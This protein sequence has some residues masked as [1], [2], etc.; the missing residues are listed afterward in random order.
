MANF[1]PKI[2]DTGIG[3]N[4]PVSPV[5]D[6][7]MGDLFANVGKVGAA[8]F[9]VADQATQDNIKTQIQDQT[10][11]IQKEYGVQAASTLYGTD[12]SSPSQP[13]PKTLE[14]ASQTLKDNQTAFNQGRMN[15]TTYITRLD[16]MTRQ[17]KSQYPAYSDQIDTIVSG[18][19]GI[20]PANALQKALMEDM[21]SSA[22]ANATAH[23]KS[24]AYVLS[25]SQYAPPGA[26]ESINSGKS[27]VPEVMDFIQRSKSRE[28]SISQEKASIAA[29]DAANA[30]DLNKVQ[31]SARKIA[32]ISVNE[33]IAKGIGA[34]GT[35]YNKFQSTLNAAGADGAYTAEENA[36]IR[37][38]FNQL[39]LAAQSKLNSTFNDPYNDS[40]DSYATKLSY[41]DIQD[42]TSSAM[43]PISA[44][45]EAVVNKDYGVLSAAALSIG[46]ASN[47]AQTQVLNSEGGG[48]IMRMSALSKL[49]G[50]VVLNSVMMEGNFKAFTDVQRATSSALLAK[51]VVDSKP[52]SDVLNDYKGTGTVDPKVVNATISAT[53]DMITKDGVNPE[54]SYN[55]AVSLFSKNT[56]EVFK[57]IK[58]PERMDLYARLTSPA[59]SAKMKR[60]GETHPQLLQQY[61]QFTGTQF[62][63]LFKGQADTVSSS[64]SE[65]PDISVKYN[66]K[67]AQF[68]LVDNS[69]GPFQKGY[70]KQTLQNFMDFVTLGVHQSTKLEMVQ[71]VNKINKGLASL[72]AA[73]SI[74]GE[75]PSAVLYRT[76]G[77]MVN[78]NKDL[79]F[80]GDLLT[81]IRD[82]V[83]EDVKNGASGASKSPDAT[84][85][86]PNSTQ[87]SE[88]PVPLSKPDAQAI[89]TNQPK[90]ADLTSAIIN[91]GERGKPGDVSPK[92]ALGHIQMMPKTA[93]AMA[94]ELGVPYDAEKLKNDPAY[95]QPLGERYIQKLKD[96][97]GDSTLAVA[98]YNAGPTK[99]S[100][101]IKEFGD[102]RT[103]SVDIVDWVNKIPYKETRDYVKRTMLAAY[104]S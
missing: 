39:K 75:D 69:S 51:T 56:D 21:A 59:V 33:A 85:T 64:T 73:M 61:L 5:V 67:T 54:A 1:N 94:K 92:G 99:V 11:S 55:A 10:N 49:V 50:P 43:A 30:L 95:A 101:W 17:M 44:I 98:A 53:M 90:F 62:V 68:D 35:S 47:D 24:M 74:T 70:G 29:D 86:S 81:A 2:Q 46:D 104:D 89:F 88:P 97:F 13:L 63:Q 19:T 57:M 6:S 65:V 8:A 83:P 71:S 78:G 45:E 4:A 82:G 27:T 36:Q 34:V 20:T 60:L 96:R 91:V 16:A 87:N 48:M 12:I 93:M 66:P 31:Q 80:Y 84:Q 32:T 40:G 23:D 18:V 72:K 9:T 102:P 79:G 22:K 77:V 7:S 58:T 26:I 38:Q 52:L 25:N 100:E 15:Q 41:K 103:D 76:T 37:S 3:P 14:R 42:I 28:Q